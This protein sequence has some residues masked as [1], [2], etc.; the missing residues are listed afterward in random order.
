MR[1]FEK[2]GRT[3]RVKIVIT[4]GSDCG[5]ALWIKIFVLSSAILFHYKSTHCAVCTPTF[6]FFFIGLFLLFPAAKTV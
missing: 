5:S 6:F 2:W 3:T 1:D 4:T